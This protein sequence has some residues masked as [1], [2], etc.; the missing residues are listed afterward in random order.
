MLLYLQDKLRGG[1]TGVGNGDST[2]PEARDGYCHSSSADSSDEDY[3]ISHSVSSS[4]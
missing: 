4:Q 2:S 3:E 1:G